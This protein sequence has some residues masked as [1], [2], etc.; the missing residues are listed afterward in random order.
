MKSFFTFLTHKT[1]RI[2]Y[3]ITLLIFLWKFLPLEIIGYLTILNLLFPIFLIGVFGIF[4]LKLILKIKWRLLDWLMLLFFAFQITNYFNL[5]VSTLNENKHNSLSILSYNTKSLIYKK[6]HRYDD[7][8][9][10]IRDFIKENDPDIVCLQETYWRNWN[11]GYPYIGKSNSSYSILSKY[12]IIKQ[13]ILPIKDAKD[14]NRFHFADIEW[15]K[16][17]IRVINIHLASY[18]FTKENYAVIN[19]IN[20]LKQEDVKIGIKSTLNKLKLG[21]NRKQTQLKKLEDF[22][23]KS[24]YPIFLVGD[25]NDIAH[26]NTYYRLTK[27]L[28]DS[29]KSKGN[30]FGKTLTSFI[31]PLRIDYILYPESYKCVKHE[32]LSK[33]LSDHL[34]INAFFVKENENE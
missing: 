14:L 15:K 31:F 4:I 11:F 23:S 28:K 29:Y 18:K 7:N 2:I 17:T 32:V 20:N 10:A 12:P 9:D 26:S 16:D 13:G 21:L 1:K 30:G 34:A 6:E 24:P 25:F 19:D 3:F 22:I 5:S 33:K 27:N 8:H